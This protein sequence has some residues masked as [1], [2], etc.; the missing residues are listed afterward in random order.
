MNIFKKAQGLV[1]LVCDVC[2][3]SSGYEFDDLIVCSLCNR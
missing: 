2:L 1:D 3:D